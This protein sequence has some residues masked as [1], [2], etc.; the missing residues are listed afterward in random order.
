MSEDIPTGHIIS[1]RRNDVCIITLNDPERLN[2]LSDEMRG[3]LVPALEA[4]MWDNSVRVV[5]LTGAGGNF[6]AGADI[7]QLSVSGHPDP[8]RSRRRLVPLHRAVELIAAGPKPVITAVEGAC[9]GAGLSFAAASDFV[10][11]DETARFGAA[12]GKIGLTADCGLIW[13]LPQRVGRTL[14]RDLMFTG[15]PVKIEEAERIGLVD[16][17]VPAG[18]ALASALEKVAEYRSIAPLSIAAMKS[19]FAQGPG[20]LAE[21]LA[22]EQQQQ[23][24]LSMTSDHAEGINAFREK[25]ST[26]FTG[27]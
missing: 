13:S 26:S 3:A 7:R 5:V 11:A 22:L 17:Q 12:F 15:R 8:L 9:F 24:M 25:R 21:A 16:R 10:I 4:A 23:P 1:E 2:P 19:A 14:A 6:T 18:I 20:S 27:N